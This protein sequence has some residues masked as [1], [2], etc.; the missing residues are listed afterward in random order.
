MEAAV[1]KP[2]I[3]TH[4][5]GSWRTIAILGLAMILGLGFVAGFALPYFTGGED[6]ARY[7]GR[8]VWLF[9]HLGGG[10]IALLVGPGQLWLGQKRRRLDVHRRLGLA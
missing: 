6:L 4:A 5:R 2:P 9:M 3:S 7:P 8:E 10:M 1:I